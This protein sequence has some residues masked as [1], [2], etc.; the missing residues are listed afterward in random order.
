MSEP[1]FDRRLL[2]LLE[3]CRSH[4]TEQDD[5]LLAEL[6]AA[7]S[8]GA[9]LEQL[10]QRIQKIDAKLSAALHDVCPPEGLSERIKQRLAESRTAAA[11]AAR[12]E[13]AISGQPT[14]SDRSTDRRRRRLLGAAGA[15]LLAVAASLFVAVWLARPAPQTVSPHQ[16]LDWAIARFNDEQDFAGVFESR[17]LAEAPE[18]YPLSA[19]VAQ[20]AQIQWRQLAS[21][22]GDMPQLRW[23]GVAYDFFGPQGLLATLYVLQ[24]PVGGLPDIPPASPNLSTGMCSAAIWQEDGLVYVLVLRGGPEEYRQLVQIRPGPIA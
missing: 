21:S 3:V 5:P 7:F 17:P 23:E 9:Q 11:I 16:L 4:G 2:E 1:T 18:K 19:F 14:A 6:A 15:A 8:D 12:A 10:L 13:K 22:D 20:Q 24:A